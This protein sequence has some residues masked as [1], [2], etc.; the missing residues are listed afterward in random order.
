MNHLTLEQC[1]KLKELGFP[2]DTWFRYGHVSHKYEVFG[3]DTGLMEWETACPTLEELI[4]WL[5]QE[6]QFLSIVE[7]QQPHYWS[8]TSNDGSG[9]GKNPLEAVY[10]L[11][12]AVKE[13]HA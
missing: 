1:E 4:E 2:Q 11:A 12:C 8:A 10:L 13:N 5:N 9:K 7:W 6:D 3:E